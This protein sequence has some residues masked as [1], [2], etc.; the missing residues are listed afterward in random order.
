V[1]RPRRYRSGV[2]TRITGMKKVGFAPITGPKPI[3]WQRLR[4][5]AYRRVPTA[6]CRIRSPFFLP[7]PNRPTIIKA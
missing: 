5:C 6:T 3:A 4:C 7:Y 2:K 1:N